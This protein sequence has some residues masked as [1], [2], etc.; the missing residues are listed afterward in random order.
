[1]VETPLGSGVPYSFYHWAVLRKSQAARFIYL[2]SKM[3]SPDKYAGNVKLHL[4]ADLPGGE[5][6]FSDCN[7]DGYS[8]AQCFDRPSL[9]QEGHRYEVERKPVDLGTWHTFRIEVDPAT[10]TFTYYIDSQVAGSHVPVDAED[11]KKAIFTLAI[12]VY[13]WEVT[14]YIEDVRVGQIRQ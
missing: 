14:G 9:Q 2:N 10:M 6:W 11:L 8:G 1:M 5:G 7:I 3:L 12:G 4:H 13:G